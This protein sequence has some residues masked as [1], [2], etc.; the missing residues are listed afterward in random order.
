MVKSGSLWTIYVRR[1]D[2]AALNAAGFRGEAAPPAVHVWGIPHS[3]P[4][5]GVLIR[6]ADG[7]LRA[8]LSRRP[9]AIAA[10]VAFA[11]GATSGAMTAVTSPLILT[12]CLGGQFVNDNYPGIGNG[13]ISRALWWLDGTTLRRVL[14]Q[15]EKY[16]GEDGPSQAATYSA[17]TALITSAAG[18]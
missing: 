10:R 11:S 13:I 3:D 16:A 1:G 8:D 12:A 6:A 9:L 18:L 4:G 15:R 17:M 5:F 7:S 14:V 2:G